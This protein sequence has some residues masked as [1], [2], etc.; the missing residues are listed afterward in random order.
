MRARTILTA[1]SWYRPNNGDYIILG[2][3]IERIYGRSYA[4]VLDERILRPLGLRATG[5]LRQSSI[6]AGLANTYFFRDD[7]KRIVPDLPAYPENWYAAGALYSTTEDLLKFSD[8]LFGAQLL[9][10]PSLAK[11]L[12]PGLDNYGYGLWSYQTDIGGKK[13]RVVKR[14]GQ[15]MGAQSQLYRFV[16]LPVTV[17]ILSN[18]G[19]TDL[20]E[21]VAE[22]GKRVVDSISQGR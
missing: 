18:T 6:I 11:M 13:Y 1:R 8:A 2:K 12:Q 21:F 15:I 14:P 19:T 7:L 17:I 9:Q 10:A 4:E 16:D 20:D 3:I 22:I 5:M